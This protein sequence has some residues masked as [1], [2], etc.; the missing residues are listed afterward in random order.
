MPSIESSLFAI[1]PV[2]T[3]ETALVAQL[4]EA[5]LK[6]AKFRNRVSID[7]S[8]YTH[9]IPGGLI[10]LAVAIRELKQEDNFECELTLPV[11]IDMTKVKN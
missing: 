6:E 10:A 4:K 1:S 5:I 2:W 8:K 11:Y 7:I 9:D 3:N